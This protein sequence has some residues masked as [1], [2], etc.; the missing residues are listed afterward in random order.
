MTDAFTQI[1]FANIALGGGILLVLTLR[2]LAR[3]QFGPRL[4]Y[5]LW[6]LPPLAAIASLLPPRIN[7]IARPAADFVDSM[8]YSFQVSYDDVASTSAIALPPPPAAFD[9]VVFG[10]LLWIAGAIAMA[11]WLTYSQLRFLKEMRVGKAGPAVVG[12]LR[13][14][15][16]TPSDFEDRFDPRERSVIITHEAIHLKRQDARVNALVAF[17]RVVVWFNPL[18]HIAA[19][20]LRIDQE[21]ACDATVIER[22]PNARRSY[23]GALLK[24]QL[25]ARPLPLGCYWPSDAD[26]PLTERIAML[27]RNAPGRTRRLAGA[28]MLATVASGASLAAWAA[29]PVQ[30]RYVVEQ[31][32]P[33]M[34]AAASAIDMTSSNVPAV[35]PAP[36]PQPP[37]AVEPAKSQPEAAAGFDRNDTIAVQGNITRI[38]GTGPS[39]FVW[40]QATD[41]FRKDGQVPNTQLWRL[42][43][44]K[45]TAPFDRI[46]VGGTI[47]VV[48]FNAADKSCAANCRLQ[49]TG[50]NLSMKGLPDN[51]YPI[52]FAARPPEDQLL[53][54]QLHSPV[55]PA[56][57]P[58]VML[59]QATSI[60]A[61]RIT[62]DPETG[63]TIYEGNV[64]ILVGGA[65]MKTDRIVISSNKGEREAW[66][67]WERIGPNGSTKESMLLA[68]PD[69]LRTTPQAGSVVTLSGRRMPDGVGLAMPAPQPPE[70]ELRTSSSLLP[71]EKPGQPFAALFDGNAPILL[72]GKVTKVELLDPNSY[73][74]VEAEETL[75]KV[76]IARARLVP[77]YVKGPGFVGK[78]IIVRG[79]E[80]KDKTCKPECLIHGRDVTADGKD[81]LKFGWTLT[82]P[83]PAG[84]PAPIPAPAKPF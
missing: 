73:I 49:V 76:M 6:L 51:R 64:Q 23:A 66:G 20:Y 28:T 58:P 14:R 2:K 9:P 41:L 39:A 31:Q 29:L 15:I 82:P 47:R 38:E 24:A 84:T 36:A 77:D 35:Q 16:V 32:A 1:L 13:P 3:A 81:D 62:S 54:G 10:A 27:K 65:I 48:G 33:G 59:A 53:F 42:E 17:T 18:V 43:T 12:F 69:P 44:P 72:T 34:D 19:H 71:G 56:P 45:G 8:T 78:K 50:W 25:A 68:P 52:G 70:V 26:H 75:Y 21:L 37:A 79:Y 40:L 63:D 67:V 22:H 55:Y 57:I 11:T 61:D 46:K 5:S 83:D 30:E 4:A 74:W 80:A 60:T 7:E